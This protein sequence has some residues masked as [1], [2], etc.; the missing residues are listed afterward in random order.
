M[1]P[2]TPAANS[3]A[4]M[5]I[6]NLPRV[7]WIASSIHQR[8]PATVV[9]EDLV[10]IGVLGLIESVDRYDPRTNVQFKTFAEYR[11]RGAILDS[12]CEL[13]GIPA[14][15]G[16]VN[17]EAHLHKQ[18]I[19]GLLPLGQAAGRGRDADPERLGRVVEGERTQLF[20]HRAH[21][22][23]GSA[24][25]RARTVAVDEE[26]LI[27][28]VRS[29]GQEIAAKAEQIAVARIETGD[30]PAAHE[31]DLVRHGDT[32]DRRASDVIVGDQKRAGN[33]AEHA[34]LM[35]H[36]HQIRPRRRLDLAHDL[37]FIAEF[38]VAPFAHGAAPSRVETNIVP[39]VSAR[40]DPDV[41]GKPASLG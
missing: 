11:I 31:R 16:V 27:D 15:E 10:S 30:G 32:R 19:G 23:L 39:S 7:R 8:L 21:R 14:G 9:L 1:T 6:E 4:N 29:R 24:R 35:P 18:K 13:D 40:R 25:T 26:E 38:C 36:M 20:D 41:I 3:R 22:E 5:I 28:S 34:D 12:V 37:E 17:R 33:L 2:L